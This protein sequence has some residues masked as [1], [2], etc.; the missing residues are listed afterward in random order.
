MEFLLECIGFP[1]DADFAELKRRIEQDGEQAPWRG[2]GGTH[3][4]LPLAGGI[5][6]FLDREKGQNFETVMPQC[7][8]PHRLRVATQRLLKIPDS[9]YDALLI[10]QANPLVEHYDSFDGQQFQISTFLTDRRRLPSTV[11]AGHVFA[12][13]VAGFALDVTYSGPNEGV[14]DRAIFDNPRGAL[15]EPLGGAEDPGGCMDLSL[16]VREILHVRNPLT[17]HLIEV[18]EADAPGR[19][20]RL[21]VSRWQLDQDELPQPRPGWRIEGTFMLTG[22]ITGGLPRSPRRVQRAFG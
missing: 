9:P 14:R 21:F 12:I 5:E 10:G 17:G 19:P 8:V 2:P 22:R 11:K 15:L 1:P 18:I 20:L 4:R 7:R 6:L 3:L 16:R 13:G